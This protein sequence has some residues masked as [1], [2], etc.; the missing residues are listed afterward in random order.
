M[1]EKWGTPF[2]FFCLSSI[3]LFR[4]KE[5][6]PFRRHDHRL[7]YDSNLRTTLRARFTGSIPNE[8][9]ALVALTYLDLGSTSIEGTLKIKEMKHYS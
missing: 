9:G 1:W 3:N 4:E 6:H 5:S 2:S 7:Q 8:I